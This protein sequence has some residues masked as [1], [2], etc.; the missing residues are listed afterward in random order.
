MMPVPTFLPC[1][2]NSTDK[3]RDILITQYFSQ[4][5]M[6]NVEIISFLTIH[7]GI[8][9]S[10]LKRRL[11]KL[12]QRRRM[13]E[14]ESRNARDDQISV[15]LTRKRLLLLIFKYYPQKPNGGAM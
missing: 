14:L 11:R 10:T 1:V 2:A 9:I 3:G 6:T 4:N 7:H 5:M 8:I 13:D 12:G 15:A